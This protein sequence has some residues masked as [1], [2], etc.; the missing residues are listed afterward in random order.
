MIVAIQQ[1]NE[2]T[3]FVCFCWFAGF[4]V[5]MTSALKKIAE[6]DDL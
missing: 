2:A 4:F 1:Q 3:T 6:L 5:V